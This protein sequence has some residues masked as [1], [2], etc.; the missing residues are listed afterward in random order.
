MK[1]KPFQVPHY[2]EHDKEDDGRMFT[3]ISRISKKDIEKL[4][5]EFK[6]NVMHAAGIDDHQTTYIIYGDNPPNG[7]GSMFSFGFE[8]SRLMGISITHHLGTDQDDMD[9]KP[10]VVNTVYGIPMIDKKPGYVILGVS[11]ALSII[12]ERKHDKA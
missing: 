1:Y 9:I 7:F 10:G 8:F 12:E 4:C 3:P 2:V 5:E 11:E 6:T